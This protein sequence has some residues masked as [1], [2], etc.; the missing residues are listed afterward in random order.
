MTAEEFM[1]DKLYG[2]EAYLKLKS[3]LVDIFNEK[4][5]YRNNLI[6]TKCII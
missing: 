4:V 3:R 5:S 6:L 1:N 2:K